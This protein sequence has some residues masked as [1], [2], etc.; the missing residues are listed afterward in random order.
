MTRK[1]IIERAKLLQ[2]WSL[3][4]FAAAIGFMVAALLAKQWLF[5][6]LDALFAIINVALFAINSMIIARA[7]IL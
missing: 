6:T 7:R 4:L 2:A 1:Q 5:V 3:L